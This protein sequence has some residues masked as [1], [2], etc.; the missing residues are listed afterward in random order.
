ME[1]KQ[2]LVLEIVAAIGIG[3][4]IIAALLIF[5]T[6]TKNENQSTH[7]ENIISAKGQ[8]AKN[9][10]SNIQLPVLNTINMKKLSELYIDTELGEIAQIYNEMLNQL[11]KEKYIIATTYD[12]DNIVTYKTELDLQK[13]IL[14]VT[15]PNEKEV[16]LDS[17]NIYEY[18]LN[19][20]SII[21][22]EHNAPNV[23]KEELLYTFMLFNVPDFNEIKNSF[24]F[25]VCDDIKVE[26]NEYYK[27]T[28][29]YIGNQSTINLYIDKNTSRLIEI[30]GITAENKVTNIASFEYANNS[31]YIPGI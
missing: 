4:L 2:I 22:R 19:S 1:K 26:E 24:E 9:N 27:I 31:I 21:K 3:I 20:E 29:K 13:N 14:K 8:K 28:A 16:Y 15:V 30:N 25:E 10:N 23:E 18:N 12:E 11:E 17:K 6:N 7:K 5:G